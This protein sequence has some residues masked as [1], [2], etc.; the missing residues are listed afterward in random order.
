MPHPP[1]IILD[2]KSEA[3]LYRQIYETI[4]CSI[5]SG[6]F[7][8][9]RQLP[10]SRELAKQ[11]NVSRLT[12]VNAYDQLLAEGYL[13]SKRGAGTFVAEHL[14]EEFL[15]SPPVK[16]QKRGA[17]TLPR[18]ILLSRYGKNVLQESSTILQY[19]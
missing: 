13:E 1:F 4:R 12:V 17:K 6:E 7:H 11:L 19:N 3:P 10:S 2:E 5:L 14:P 18:P 8:S 15:Q 16:Q 9:G